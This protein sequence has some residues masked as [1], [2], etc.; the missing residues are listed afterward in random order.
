[1]VMPASKEKLTM[2]FAKGKKNVA[3]AQAQAEQ[4]L[5]SV[6]SITVPTAVEA[7]AKLSVNVQER[8]AALTGDVQQQVTQLQ[9]VRDAITIEKENLD[10]LHKIKVEASTLDDLQADIAATKET[11]A[12]EK[13]E[14]EAQWVADDAERELQRKRADEQYQFTLGVTRR[15][16]QDAWQSE[17]D[18]NKRAEELR[19]EILKREWAEREE[20]LAA[21]EK[22]LTEMRAK[23]DRYDEDLKKAVDAQVNQRAGAIQGDYAQK[24]ALAQMEAKQTAAI[25]AAENASLKSQL[26]LL[27]KQLAAA[28]VEIQSAN[29]RAQDTATKAL[30]AASGQGALRAL[31]EDRSNRSDQVQGKQR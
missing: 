13:L 21:A 20:T 10:T 17:F 6:K 26:A 28:Q 7:M 22:E 30:E 18:T 2:A 11:W 5:T 3:I 8:L 14:R 4:I 24:L 31:Q 27:D 25:Q 12:A 16:V 9:N 23:F 19:R 29:Q 15:N 1:M